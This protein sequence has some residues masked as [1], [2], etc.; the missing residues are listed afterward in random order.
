MW[1]DGRI[2]R[3]KDRQTDMTNLIDVF[4]ILRTD[5]KKTKKTAGSAQR[6][7]NYCQFPGKNFG[8]I[9]RDILIF[10]TI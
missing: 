1:T 6:L 5:K 7:L 8:D 4:A 10:R 2:D 9:S 3:Q